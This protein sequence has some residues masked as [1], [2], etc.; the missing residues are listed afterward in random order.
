LSYLPDALTNPQAY[1]HS[2]DQVNLI[3]TH[4]SWVFLTGTYVYK[5][6]KPVCFDFVDFSSLAKRQFFCAEEVRC[7]EAFAP[8]LYLGVVPIVLRSDGRVVVS[9]ES[10]LSDDEIIE[11]AVHMLEFDGDLQ[12]DRLLEHDQLGVLEIREF[13]AKLAAQHTQLPELSASYEPGQAITDNFA[14]LRGLTCIEPFEELLNTLE[15]EARSQLDRT[16]D[17]LQERRHQHWVRECHG[18]LHLSNLAR[19]ENGLTAFDCLEF[20]ESL[21]HIDVWC[22]A[23]FLFMDCCVRDRADLAYAFVDGYLDESGDYAGVGLLPMFAAYRSMVRAKIAAL[24][25]EQAQEVE[26]FEKLERHL[27]WPLARKLRGPGRLFVTCGLAGSGK[28]YWA[29]QLVSA[30]P[31]IRLRS[32]VLRKSQHGMAPLAH[33]ESGLGENLY[34]SSASEAVYSSLAE[35]AATLLALGEHVIVD[36]ACLKK[37]QRM[38]LYDAAQNVGSGVSLLHFTAPLDVLRARIYSR[39]VAGDDPS[40]ADV[41]VLDWQLTAAEMPTESEP[42]IEL[43]STEMTMPKLMALLPTVDTR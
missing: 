39:G 19:L 26:V 33:S 42:L 13:G 25:F 43:D 37:A 29:E 18:D 20:D 3:E 16:R 15:G 5:V 21:R 27:Q 11:Y 10:V 28:S 24:R 17:D 14:S 8:E 41:A 1:A 23:G 12:A 9:P 22:D 6:K 35:H 34:K 2:V 36:A 4:L 38:V 31:A 30:L 32:D 40:E 7:N